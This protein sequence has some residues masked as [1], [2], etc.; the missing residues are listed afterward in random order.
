ME[1]HCVFHEG[2]KAI[3]PT[4]CPM[5]QGVGRWFIDILTVQ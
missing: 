4:P 1:S 2:I 3:L 5:W